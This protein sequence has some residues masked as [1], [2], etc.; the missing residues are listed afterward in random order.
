MLQFELQAWWCLSVVVTRVRAWLSL[1]RLCLCR[2]W[3]LSAVS[4][5]SV[6]LL[7]MLTVLGGLWLSLAVVS[8]D[9]EI[10]LVSSPSR[11]A[12][13]VPLP[14]RKVFVSSR[15]PALPLSSEHF[16]VKKPEGAHFDV[17]CDLAKSHLPRKASK[18]GF[19]LWISAASSWRTSAPFTRGLE[20]QNF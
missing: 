2:M 6:S 9:R 11:V 10:S 8:P 3:L 1:C 5:P 19:R 4:S 17:Q 20:V 14:K 12:K 18:S 16:L 7:P 13:V 15:S